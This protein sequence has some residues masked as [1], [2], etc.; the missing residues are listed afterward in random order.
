MRRRLALA[1][2]SVV[3][4]AISSALPAR[5]AD[6]QSVPG[7]GT[8]VGDGSRISTSIDSTAAPATGDVDEYVFDGYDGQTLSVLVTGRGALIPRVSLRRPDGTSVD[9]ED[10]AR[11]R[12]APGPRLPAPKLV[13]VEFPLDGTGVWTIRIEGDRPS[14]K[15]VDD[16]RT[17]EN[18]GDDPGTDAYEHRY[19]RYD[20]TRPR[21]SGPY[22]LAVRLRGAPRVS[23]KSPFPD[24]HEGFVRFAVPGAGGGRL[25]TSLRWRFDGAPAFESFRGPDGTEIPGFAAALWNTARSSSARKFVLPEALPV[26]DCV[27]TY[28]FPPEV[29]HVG[30]RFT[31][32][33][34]PPRASKP[35]R[36]KLHAEE[37]VVTAVDPAVG[38]PGT[39]VVVSCARFLD[40]ER[41]GGAP[42]V[43]FGRF[44]AEDVEAVDGTTLRCRTPAILPEGTW[45]VVVE[46][47]SGQAA[48]RAQAFR[49]LPPPIATGL[50]PTVGSWRG[51]FDVTVSGMRFNPAPN[52]MRIEFVDALSGATRTVPVAFDP[53]LQSEVRI[54]FS[55][56]E[57][58]LALARGA[59]RVRV[60]D[61]RSGLSAS[62][63]GTIEVTDRPV[64]DRLSPALVPVLGGDEVTVHGAEFD[65]SAEVLLED[66]LGSDTYSPVAT[67]FHDPRRLSFTA[68]ARPKGTWRVKVSSL[69]HLS[70]AA[71]YASFEFAALPLGLPAGDDPWDATSSALGD[72][73]GDGDEDLVLARALTGVEAR[74]DSPQTRVLRN[75]GA[76]TLVDVTSSVV[77]AVTADDDWRAD[78]VAC[79]DLDDDGFADV[80]I[81]TNSRTVPAETRCHTRILMSEPRADDPA[82]RVLRD[83]TTDLMPAP[84]RMSRLYGPGVVTLEDWRGKDIWI[85]DLDLAGPGPPEIVVTHDETKEDV[86]VGCA[87]YCA[88]PY[89]AWYPYAFYWGGSRAFVWDRHARGGLGRYKFARNYFPQKA[90]LTIRIAGAPPGVAIPICNSTSPCRGTFTPFAGDRLAVGDLDGDERPDVAVL[91]S[92]GT[93]ASGE[94]VSRPLQVALTRGWPGQ[95]STLDVT[96]LVPS[97]APGDA[98]AIGRTQ[99]PAGAVSGLIAVARSEPPS[100]GPALRLW[101]HRRGSVPSDPGDFEEVTSGVLPDP[102][103]A[104]DAFQASVLR[105]LD[106]DQDGDDDL[107]LLADAAP[108]GTAPALRILRS[109]PGLVGGLPTSGVF[110][111]SLGPLLEAVRDDVGDA[112]DGVALAIGDLDGDGALDFVVSRSAAGT[113][114]GAAG[115]RALGID[116][117]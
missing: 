10:G 26:G 93:L 112:F 43:L 74:Q 16:P 73:D 7:A 65:A 78:R 6:P 86:E 111:S 53:L 32:S 75:D 104:G 107:V 54:V 100:S 27:L 68:P 59:Y 20:V 17:P 96:S 63:P 28:R 30:L 5:A 114:G 106:L 14:R 52:G 33:L 60:T 109:E 51:G 47:T 8:R 55:M 89:A 70:P 84:R 69:G 91:A 42:R 80:V 34:K 48:A 77:P 24:D 23:S 25:S 101:R 64:I 56:P 35:L 50:A 90:A 115:T 81:T 45:D 11:F 61:V 29:R 113:A 57:G 22:E 79:A 108:G 2:A 1:L 88:S 41:P 103:P 40:P 37:P 38:G 83:R 12:P 92:S 36:G 3:L 39:N 94:D 19:F 58:A 4:P 44:P 31:A 82:D 72:F 21:T 71:A 105:F 67:T 49:R 87:P 85:G 76:G 116:R 102:L 13:R 99:F 62:A 97:P 98:V 95:P 46:S 110:R 15:F 66:A 117:P 18:E 9:P